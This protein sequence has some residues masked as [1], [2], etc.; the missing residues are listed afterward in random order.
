MHPKVG[1]MTLNELGKVLFLGTSKRF[2]RTLALPS[3]SDSQV[4]WPVSHAG[5]GATAFGWPQTR[6]S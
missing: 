2:E 1:T 6:G 3:V 4:A 5:L